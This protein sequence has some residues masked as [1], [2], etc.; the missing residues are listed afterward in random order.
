MKGRCLSRLTNGPRNGSGSGIRTYDLPGMNRT[1]WPTELCRHNH[2]F[3]DAI[4]YYQQNTLMSRSFSDILRR[5]F[6]ESFR[7]QKRLHIFL[8][9]V[10]FLVTEMAL[11]VDPVW[12]ACKLFEIV[13]ADGHEISLH[14]FP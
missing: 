11:Q 3:F 7:I 12:I 10:V 6:E 4:K 1:L 9:K 13:P 14:S 8:R 5:I 2:A